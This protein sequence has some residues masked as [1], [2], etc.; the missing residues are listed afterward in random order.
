MS[1]PLGEVTRTAKAR[2][3]RP[4]IGLIVIVIATMCVSGDAL[5]EKIAKQWSPLGLSAVNALYA[6]K[7]WRWKQGAAFF[8]PD[9]HFKAW[10]RAGGKLADGRGA[11]DLRGDGVMCFTA[12][13]ENVPDTAGHGPSQPA[14]TC[15]DHEARGSAIA[16]RKLPDG[17]WYFF[18]HAPPQK[19]DEFFKLETG[20][21][22]RLSS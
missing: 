14:E 19:T 15:F 22:T 11:W 5:A 16:Q 8:S 7:T 1:S 6:G 4:G 20:D 17:R 21:R 12:T 10:S 2:F 3:S 18:K 13:W 9:G